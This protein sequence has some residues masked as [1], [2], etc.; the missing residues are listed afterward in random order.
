MLP[1]WLSWFPW[2]HFKGHLNLPSYFLCSLFFMDILCHN[3]LKVSLHGDTNFSLTHFLV[4][5]FPELGKW[6]FKHAT[7]QSSYW[8]LTSIGL[9]N[10]IV[11]GDVKL[12]CE[13][14]LFCAVTIWCQSTNSSLWNF[15][16]MAWCWSVVRE[17]LFLHCVLWRKC[18]Q[19]GCRVMV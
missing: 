9:V 1:I 19:G 5:F 11:H 14:Y 10:A 8:I 17:L 7:M 13:S 18:G 3:C 15:A 16:K 12:L 6:A 2:M 4:F